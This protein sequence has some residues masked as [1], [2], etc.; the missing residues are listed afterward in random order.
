MS[1]PQKALKGTKLRGR[2]EP[3]RR[4]SLIFADSQKMRRIW[5]TQ[6]FAENRRSS[7]ETAENRRNPHK[8]A[9]WRLGGEQKGGEPRKVPRSTFLEAK[10]LLRRSLF[11]WVLRERGPSKKRACFLEGA[12]WNFSWVA[13]L[14]PRLTFVPLGL[15]PY[16]RGPGPTQTFSCGCSVPHFVGSMGL[17]RQVTGVS[18]P[19]EPKIARKSQK[20]SFGGPQKSPRKYPKKV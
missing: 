5:E 16:K 1:W 4:L 6:I 20:E 12:A 8:T 18:G 13:P 14:G 3:K 19:S 2:I 7:Q 11:P 10:G 17:R 9:D 15:S